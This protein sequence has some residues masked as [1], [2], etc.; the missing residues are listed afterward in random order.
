MNQMC[1]QYLAC[2]SR[3]WW[4]RILSLAALSEW[5]ELDKFSKTKKSPI[6]Y[7]PFVDVCLKYDKRSEAQKYLTRVKDDLKV[8]Y[9][10]KLG[11]LE[12]ANNVA[13]EHRD[14]QALLF[15]QSRCGTAEKTLSDRIDATI[16][17][18]TAKK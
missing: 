18:L 7:E 10:L 6:G 1:I 14:V 15:V 3:Y 8:K 12:E 2:V 16:A 17:Q 13:T 9:Y 4:L 11:M 5:S